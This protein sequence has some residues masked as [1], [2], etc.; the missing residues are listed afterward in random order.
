MTF[1]KDSLA[2][3][4]QNIRILPRT[5]YAGWCHFFFEA[6]GVVQMRLFRLL[7]GVI[8]FFAYALRSIDSEL[9]FGANGLLDIEKMFESLPMTYRWSFLTWFPSTVVLWVHTGIFLLALLTMAFGIF[10]RVSALIAFLLHVSYM[11]RNMAIVYGLDMIST[12]FLFYLIFTNTSLPK[13]KSSSPAEGEKWTD[14]LTSAAFRMTQI[15]LCVIY[16]YSGWEKLKGV[17]WWRG[18]AIWMVFANPQYARFEAN[19]FSHLPLVVSFIS[20]FTLLWEMYF[21]VCVWMPRLRPWM[22]IGGVL[23]HFGIGVAILIP[24][25]SA[26]MMSVYVTFLTQKDAQWLWDQM[27]YF[28]YVKPSRFVGR[29]R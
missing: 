8:L 9:F 22:L 21:P 15:Q 2:G 14:L 1:E 17:Q 12:F 6:D 27:I 19:W 28:L 23:M 7:F 20:Y 18:E 26:V 10:P 11:H 25:F 3:I 24:F 4:F 13:T 16:A 5:A 29:L